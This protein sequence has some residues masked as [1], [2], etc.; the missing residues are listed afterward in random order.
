M[1]QRDWLV[2]ILPSQDR[3]DE[4]LGDD[5]ATA[6]LGLARSRAPVEPGFADVL[7][8]AKDPAIRAEFKLAQEA[9]TALKSDSNAVLSAE[10]T[11]AMHALVHLLLR[12]ALRV[13][14]GA[15]PAIPDSWPRLTSAH[16]T[17][18]A[19]THGVGRVDTHDR[20]H[21]GTGWFATRDILMT[22]RHVA[23]VLC[24]L[25]VHGDPAWLDK[26]PAAVAAT[27]G[28][29]D[30]DPALRAVWDPAEAPWPESPVKG[31]ITRIRAWHPDLDMALL[32]VTGVADGAARVLNI[33]AL[34]PATLVGQDCYL[35]GYPAVNPPFGVSQQVAELLFPGA[36]IAGLKR[37]SPGQLAG[38]AADLPVAPDRPRQRHDGSTLGGSSG[39]P[40]FDFDTHCV[41]AIHYKG[42]YGVENSAVPFWL[43][44][45]EAFFA[46]NG[47]RFAS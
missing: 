15:I 1:D 37:V 22:N 25:D 19:R 39:S 2:S 20:A 12:P 26:L 4:L 8:P 27:N 35:V 14:D 32:D 13:S 21:V 17:V 33:R 23:G 46:E 11:Q 29:W 10:Q 18:M 3:L 45:D 47:I 38:L 41:V 34:P 5:P 31:S 9:A 42:R 40:V 43:V 24:G 28:A 6:L 16:D 7:D 30:K 44:K 36:T